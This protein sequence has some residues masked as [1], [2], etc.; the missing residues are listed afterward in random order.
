MQALKWHWHVDIGGFST[1]CILVLGLV[2]SEYFWWAESS[3][4]EG[5]VCKDMCH[6]NAS[7]C[8]K[9]TWWAVYIKP[10]PLLSLYE[11]LD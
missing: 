7:A 10:K 3:F 8:T 1:Q 5:G 2:P 9:V 11:I 4:E 6:L